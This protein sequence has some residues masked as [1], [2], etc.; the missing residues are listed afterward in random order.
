MISY[1]ESDEGREG[2]SGTHES[3]QSNRRGINDECTA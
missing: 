1:V 2:G 3:I